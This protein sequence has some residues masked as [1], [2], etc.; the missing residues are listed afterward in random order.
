VSEFEKEFKKLNWLELNSLQW[1]LRHVTG[2]NYRVV[3]GEGWLVEP[4]LQPNYVMLRILG[5]E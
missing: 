1:W 4:F 5:V 3:M 2:I